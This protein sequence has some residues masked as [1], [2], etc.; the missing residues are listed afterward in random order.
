[1]ANYTPFST[2]KIRVGALG[3]TLSDADNIPNI[4]SVR[5]STAFQEALVRTAP[6]INQYPTAD[7]QYDSDLA[8]EWETTSLP[9][10]MFPYVLGVSGV[11]GGGYRTYTGTL[12]AKPAYHQ[13]EFVNE[14]P[15]GKEIIINLPRVK[16]IGMNPQF[17]RDGFQTAAFSSRSLP[18]DSYAPYIIRI[19]E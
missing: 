8:I 10:A 2:G 18:V 19:E 12:V 1:M 3:V 16:T 11:S 14:T 15:D 6:F 5:L 4:Q 17:S 7:A 13:V 9:E